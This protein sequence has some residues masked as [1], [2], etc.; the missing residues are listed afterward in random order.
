M[1]VLIIENIN[2]KY[3]MEEKK[4]LKIFSIN[5]SVFCVSVIIQQ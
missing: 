4:K 1:N 2:L 5:Y 3:L